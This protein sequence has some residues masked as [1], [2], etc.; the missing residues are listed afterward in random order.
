MQAE[1]RGDWAWAHSILQEA[2]RGQQVWDV[3]GIQNLRGGTGGTGGAFSAPR[4]RAPVPGVGLPRGRGRLSLRDS[5]GLIPTRQY[6]KPRQAVWGTYVFRVPMLVF[7]LSSED[8]PVARLLQPRA[9]LRVLEGT[10]GRMVRS[11]KDLSPLHLS[12]STAKGEIGFRFLMAGAGVFELT[13]VDFCLSGWAI[14][15]TVTS[16]AVSFNFCGDG[17]GDG[18]SGEAALTIL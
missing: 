9:A 18:L 15:A 5:E 7:S 10:R 11:L 16:A 17:W 13:L 12:K 2:R 3:D 8:F 4:F 1:M 14:V 6:V